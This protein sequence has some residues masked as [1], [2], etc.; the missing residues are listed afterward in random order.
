MSLENKI[1]RSLQ[2]SCAHYFS[3]LYSMLGTDKF[4]ILLFCCLF[5]FMFEITHFL[6]KVEEP[7]TARQLPYKKIFNQRYRRDVILQQNS[8]INSYYGKPYF[9]KFVLIKHCIYPYGSGT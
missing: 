8:E 6:K 2:P 3:V 5:T 4:M 1:S 7:L 9:L